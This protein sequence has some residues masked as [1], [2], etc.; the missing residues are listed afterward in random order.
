MSTVTAKALKNV[1]NFEQAFPESELS[2]KKTEDGFFPDGFHQLRR[3][4][5]SQ[6]KFY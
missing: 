3:R 6:S 1:F 2:G 4:Q 5:S